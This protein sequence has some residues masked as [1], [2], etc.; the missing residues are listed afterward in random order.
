MEQPPQLSRRQLIEGGLALAG[1]AVVAGAAGCSS[2]TASSPNTRLP[3]ESSS[4]LQTLPAPI[5]DHANPF[6]TIHKGVATART[7]LYESGSDT[8]PMS[9]EEVDA[10]FELIVEGLGA[11]AIRL[12][13]DITTV[14]DDENAFNA[15]EY[16]W[17]QYDLVL[18]TARSKGVDVLA[19]ITGWPVPLGEPGCSDSFGCLPSDQYL[20]K[21]GSFASAFAKRYD[22]IKRYQLGNEQNTIAKNGSTSE[23]PKYYVQPEH[24]ARVFNIGST[25]IKA[26]NSEA[27]VAVGAL[28]GT[29]EQQ[30]AAGAIAP[31]D[32]LYQAIKAG[33]RGFDAVTINAY[34]STINDIDGPSSQRTLASVLRDKRLNKQ[35][36]GLKDTPVLI[37]EF[38][39]P[40]DGSEESQQLQ[41]DAVLQV[42]E[43]D[44][45]LLRVG[46]RYVYDLQSR[47]GGPGI[48]NNFGLY[49]EDGTPNPAVA[50]FRD[51]P[52]KNPKPEASLS[53]WTKL[54]R[55]LT[56]RSKLPTTA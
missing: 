45:D 5:T 37:T 17:S 52:I 36:P 38:G 20:E 19:N 54:K 29:D 30:I 35:L 33:M 9:Q 24:Y 40:T 16:D 41:S 13:V 47:E 23:N 10:Q 39:T 56:A 34:G 12:D 22:W 14:F 32:F 8:I 51:T 53:S 1:L 28:A 43:Y 26:A 48:G 18:N 15:D 3:V 49:N 21:Y 2:N 11:T 50:V 7:L 31:G 6:N 44:S 25:A 4:P 55:K 27:A 42:L 46:D